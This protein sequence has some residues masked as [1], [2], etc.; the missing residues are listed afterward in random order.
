[1]ANVTLTVSVRTPWWTSLYIETLK[2]YHSLGFYVDTDIAAEF[3]VRHT[4]IEIK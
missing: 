2:L 3:I 4:K 1:M